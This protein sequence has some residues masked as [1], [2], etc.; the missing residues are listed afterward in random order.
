MPR[1]AFVEAG[2]R[3]VEQKDFGIGGEGAGQ[4]DQASRPGR[5]RRHRRRGLLPTPTRSSSPMAAAGEA[6]PDASSPTRTLS[7]ALRV[8]KSSRRWKVRARP[9][10]ARRCVLVR[11]TSAPP[12]DTEPRSGRCRPVMTLNSV[13]L[14]APLGPIRPVTMLCSARSDT[15]RARRPRR[16]GRAR[17][18]PR[19]QGHGARL[20]RRHW[21]P[22]VRRPADPDRSRP[23]ERQVYPVREPR[24][25]ED[26]VGLRASST[27]PMP[28]A[29]P[30][31]S[32]SD[33]A[34]GSAGQGAPPPSGPPAARR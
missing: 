27:I 23:A 1:L 20:V 13:V 34:G 25:A 3:F 33:V 12:R 5:E 4:L 7:T 30:V 11:V 15:S 28:A 17:D 26:A 2:A 10:R 9:R 29:S 22:R 31:R 6:F 16:N 18:R 24:H 8:E 21:P 32:A 19:G 14:P